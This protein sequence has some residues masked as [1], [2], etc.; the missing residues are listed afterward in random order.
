V[1]HARFGVRTDRRPIAPPVRLRTIIPATRRE[2]AVGV[3]PVC[4]NSQEAK[5][6]GCGGALDAR[7][8]LSLPLALG[9]LSRLNRKSR[10]TSPYTA[11]I[12][13]SLRPVTRPPRRA[14]HC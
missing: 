14:S 5:G 2:L 8:D 4:D 6:P 10:R 9:R 1:L 12:A 13:A 7:A 3:R 11:E